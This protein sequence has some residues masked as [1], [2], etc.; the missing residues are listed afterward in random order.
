MVRS[1]RIWAGLLNCELPEV[2]VQFAISESWMQGVAIPYQPG[3]KSRRYDRIG[4]AS[5]NILPAK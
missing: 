1:F 4:G 3:R 2:A 5:G